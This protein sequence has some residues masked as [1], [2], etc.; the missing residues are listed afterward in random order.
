M[1][2]FDTTHKPERGIPD[3]RPYR[4]RDDGASMTGM[5]MRAPRS[6]RHLRAVPRAVEARRRLE[7]RRARGRVWVNGR[8]LSRPDPVWAHLTVSYD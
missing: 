5:Q 4:G 2:R 7:P 3:A 8:E 6:E 1:N